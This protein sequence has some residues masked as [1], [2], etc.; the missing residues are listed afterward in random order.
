[1][2]LTNYGYSQ[3][4]I[5]KDSVSVEYSAIS[6]GIFKKIK[7]NKKTISVVNSRGG[8]AIIKSSSNS[9]W[10]TLINELKAVQVT[11]IPNLEAPSK[12]F[13]F[14]GAAIA[15]LKIIQNSNTYESMPFDHGN[16][17]AEI[18]TLVKEILSIAENIE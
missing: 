4:K 11:N 17:P 18:A 3:S 16:P 8:S 1:M 7:I 5:N 14:D 2:A 13:Q 10:E 12:S 15:H 6:R 9:N